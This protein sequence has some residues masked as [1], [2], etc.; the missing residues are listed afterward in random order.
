VRQAEYFT[1]FGPGPQ[2]VQLERVNEMQML[3]REFLRQLQVLLPADAALVPARMVEDK[4]RVFNFI[5]R[6]EQ[7]RYIRRWWRLLKRLEI[8][9]Y[10]TASPPE[11]TFA[12]PLSRNSGNSVECFSLVAGTIFRSSTKKRQKSLSTCEAECL[13]KS[14]VSSGC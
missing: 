5:Q 7:R 9:A 4:Q 14:G 6:F 2:P 1:I 3:T 13:S 12:R 10:A 8:A 11:C